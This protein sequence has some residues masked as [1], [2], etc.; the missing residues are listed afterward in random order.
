MSHW[1]DK[2]TIGFVIVFSVPT[3]LVILTW[4]SLPGNFDYP[5]KLAMENLLLLVVS[6]SYA[7]TGNLNVKYTERRS[8]EAAQLLATTQS[9]AGLVFLA[10]QVTE[11]K[12][13][14][15]AGSDRIT[16]KQLVVR[17]VKTLEQTNTKLEAQKQTMIATQSEQ[18]ER[19]RI[20]ASPTLRPETQYVPPQLSKPP[21]T[22][23][24]VVVDTPTPTPTPTESPQEV[25]DEIE[26]TQDLIEETID[27]LN[28]VT[29]NQSQGQESQGQEQVD[30]LDADTQRQGN[31]DQGQEQDDKRDVGTQGQGQGN[32][33][34]GNEDQGRGNGGQGRD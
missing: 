29:L 18:P 7:A 8:D 33:G 32:G 3:A 4:N 16:Q 14:I 11:T 31:R 10:N 23:T 9:G 34:Q 1:F 21:P 30:Q 19:T 17:Y 25:I 15:L 22:P 27:D 28:T 26:E 2:L 6:P 12:S 13:T 20:Q 5:I 24:P